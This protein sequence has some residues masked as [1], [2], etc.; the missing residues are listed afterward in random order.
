MK[1]IRSATTVIGLIGDGELAAELDAELTGT[2][3][4]LYEHCGGRKKSK[5]KGRVTLTIDLTVEDG[6]VTMPPDITTKKPKKLRE[7]G[8]FWIDAEGSISTE[9]PSQI[10]MDF[11]NRI[12]TGDALVAPTSALA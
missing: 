9:H 2:L 11:E 3:A 4:A 7:N 5:A 1:K 8:T 6:M 12:R 10:R